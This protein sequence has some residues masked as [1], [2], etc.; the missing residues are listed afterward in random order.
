MIWSL[1]IARFNRREIL[2][3]SVSA[4]HQEKKKIQCQRNCLIFTIDASLLPLIHYVHISLWFTRTVVTEWNPY[5]HVTL[6]LYRDLTVLTKITGW[7]TFTQHNVRIHTTKILV[8]DSLHLRTCLIHTP[9]EN[10]TTLKKEKKKVQL[11]KKKRGL[12]LCL[13]NSDLVIGQVRDSRRRKTKHSGF[14]FKTSCLFGEIQIVGWKFNSSCEIKDLFVANRRERLMLL[15]VNIVLAWCRTDLNITDQ[16][17]MWE[18][19]NNH[20]W[21]QTWHLRIVNSNQDDH[22]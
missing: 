8:R 5:A 6:Q 2:H 19:F 17:K 11:L 13:Y 1:F 20:W 4:L 14:K 10:M 22:L 16:R 15:T 18:A 9:W 3:K 21:G 12:L 7:T